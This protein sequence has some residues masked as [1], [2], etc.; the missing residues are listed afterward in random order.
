MDKD[1]LNKYQ[2]AYW[3][4]TIEAYRRGVR[5]GFTRDHPLMAIYRGRFPAHG[6]VFDAIEN[7]ERHENAGGLG[8]TWKTK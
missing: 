6:N 8:L 2:K 5:L 3:A 1:F 4:N 7:E